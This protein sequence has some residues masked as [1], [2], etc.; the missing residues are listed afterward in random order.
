M[1]N[2]DSSRRNPIQPTDSHS[3][4]PNQSIDPSEHPRN[5]PTHPIQAGQSKIRLRQPWKNSCKG[6]DEEQPNPSIQRHR[7]PSGPP[8]SSH[9]TQPSS[10]SKPLSRPTH[11]INSTTR[12]NHNAQPRQTNGAVQPRRNPTDPSDEPIQTIRLARPNA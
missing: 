3:S 8:N 11:S 10:R 12:L 7:N 5:K 4:S 9:P 6:L 1:Q 2:L